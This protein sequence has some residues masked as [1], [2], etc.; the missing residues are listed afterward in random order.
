MLPKDVEQ[1]EKGEKKLSSRLEKA[2]MQAHN[3]T[4]ALRAKGWEAYEFH[5]DR[6]SIVCVGSF[7]RPRPEASR[8]HDRHRSAN[9]AAHR[10]L[11]R[12]SDAGKRRHAKPQPRDV[13][14]IPF[15]VDPVPIEVP[16]RSISSAYER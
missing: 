6:S 10:H 2:A 7:P 1:I 14:D 3:M 4:V 11:R 15:D 16:Q 12:R 13:V 9:Q 5:D 8:R